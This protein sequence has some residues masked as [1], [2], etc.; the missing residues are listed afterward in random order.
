[1]QKLLGSSFGIRSDRLSG[2]FPVT[3][4]HEGIPQ[5]RLVIFEESGHLPW[6]EEPN[7]FFAE[8]E[9]FLIS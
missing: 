3:R 1:M 7:A 9:R 5:S 2:F 6:L 4:L 8:L